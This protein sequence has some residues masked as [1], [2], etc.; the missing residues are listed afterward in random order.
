MS[1]FFKCVVIW[2]FLLR[3]ALALERTEIALYDA[4]A[5]RW[6]PI[7]VEIAATSKQRQQ[8]LMGRE[9]LGENEGMLFLYP[10]EQNLSFW[11]KN[12][13]LSLDIMYFSGDRTWISTAANTTPSSLESYPAAAPAQYVLEM[14][15]GSAA[16]LNIGAG[17]RFM[18]KD[19]AQLKDQLKWGL[20]FVVCSR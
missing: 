10:R 16:R 18:I 7:W 3:P 19:C 1:I 8:G 2:L 5:G 20:D 14:I 11:M 9:F 15:A 17:S 4:E 12:T 13:P 6:H